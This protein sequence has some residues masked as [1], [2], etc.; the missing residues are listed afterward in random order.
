MTATTVG[1]PGS[2]TGK[3]GVSG[4]P[5]PKNTLA[6]V[7]YTTPDWT[8]TLLP[9]GL[10]PKQVSSDGGV[11]LLVDDLTSKVY[12]WSAGTL[13]RL[14]VTGLPGLNSGGIAMNNAGNV[15][16]NE[17][18]SIG[19]S[20]S[21][22]FTDIKIF[23][24]TDASSSFLFIPTLLTFSHSGYGGSWTNY[25]QEADLLQL[26]D[27][28]RIWFNYMDNAMNSTVNTVGK[29]QPIVTVGN[30]ANAISVSRSGHNI[31]SSSDGF[32]VDGNPVNYFPTFINDHGYILGYDFSDVFHFYPYLVYP[33]GS[34]EYAPNW[35]YPGSSNYNGINFQ[36][37]WIDSLNRLNGQHVS[38]GGPALATKVLGS[39]GQPLVPAQYQ[40]LGYVPL[41]F[42]AD[43]GW[44]TNH[45]V[46]PG[47]ISPQLGIAVNTS[48]GA[49]VPFVATRNFQLAVD[50]NR[51]G[52]IK[53]ASE[54][55]SDATPAETPFRFW[56]NDD[57]GDANIPLGAGK[58]NGVRSKVN[59]YADLVN[60]FPVFLNIAGLIKAAP[61]SDGYTYRLS[62]ADNALNFIYTALP[63]DHAFE[64]VR[65]PHPESGGGTSAFQIQPQITGFG[66]NDDIQLLFWVGPQN[67]EKTVVTAAGTPLLANWLDTIT[68]E[69]KR[70]VL[71]FDG[72]ALTEKPLVLTVVN[73][74]NV[75]VASISLP[76]QISNVEAMYRHLNLRGGPNVLASLVDAGSS[77]AGVPSNYTINP[78]GLPDA[79]NNSDWVLQM[80]GY[81]VN[82]QKSRSWES[83]VF[84]NLYW[85]H[86]HAKFVGICWFGDAHDSL[87]GSL[88]NYH[89]G[90]R[91][92]ILTAPSLAKVITDNFSGGRVTSISHSQSCMLVSSALAD[93]QA[94]IDKAI[95]VDAA[96]A[97]ECF[98]GNADEDLLNM[99]VSTWETKDSNTQASTPRYNRGLWCSN[100]W[101]QFPTTDGR[102]SLTWQNR[103]SAASPKIYNFYSSTENVLA[104]DSRDAGVV[105]ADLAAKFV[106]SLGDNVGSFSWVAQ[107]K[108]KGNLVQVGINLG[109]LPYVASGSNY[110]GWGLN[111]TDPISIDDP[112]WY[113]VAFTT[114]APSPTKFYFRALQ[115]PATINSK[116]YTPAN[117]ARSPLFLT[118]WGVVPALN[119]ES[120][121]V[122]RNAPTLTVADNTVPNWIIDLYSDSLGSNIA[123]LHRDQLLCEA[124][125]ALSLPVGAN[126]VQ[127]F[128]PSGLE[129]PGDRNFNIPLLYVD[130]NHWP[131][132]TSSA[133]GDLPIWFHSDMHDQP[134]FYMYGFYDKLVSIIAQ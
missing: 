18:K 25:Y 122:S 1:A 14:A 50:A 134:Y 44:T 109:P 48:T 119:T 66:Y 108:T 36:A 74:E 39:D 12:R 40:I 2:S 61:P 43:S 88:P 118:G 79:Y 133:Q 115:T 17:G 78:P 60:Y 73:R 59:G 82:G 45:L 94:K 46:P 113:D 72:R 16:I 121:L 114:I 103:F 55:N 31:V 90:A 15:A 56:L 4:K 32:F 120:N 10:S 30:N 84:K 21:Y 3:I 6:L 37:T 27:Q 9:G 91:N 112:I 111:L 130:S 76:L 104:K 75:V 89:A 98:D 69:N 116:S 77:D 7:Q 124:I 83:G 11:V 54:D 23:Q 125:P 49:S 57:D 29:S 26:D 97:Q 105:V 20:N 34:R 42:P 95:F 13:E 70:G 102:N 129:N 63:I 81:N 92:A 62:Q 33:N 87:W 67:A 107:E 51:D 47:T 28:N 131:R 35:L 93:A 80:H 96:L 128:A 41:V 132:G 58:G 8:I 85:S 101:T 117:I 100:W 126:P 99:T 127:N 64:Y 24:R 38:G 106:T 53:L 71:L 22:F 65:P 5:T 68:P 86:N 123:K 19:N 52:S 110:M